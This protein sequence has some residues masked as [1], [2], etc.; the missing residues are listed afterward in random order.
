MP[1][2]CACTR[3]TSTRIACHSVKIIYLY[4]VLF[5]C[6]KMYVAVP[7]Q[8][9]TMRAIYF[10]ICIIIQI[11]AFLDISEM[12]QHYSITHYNTLHMNESWATVRKE[13]LLRVEFGAINHF[14]EEPK[15]S[16]AR[17]I[18]ARSNDRRGVCRVLISRVTS[19]QNERWDRA[20]MR[21]LRF[22]KPRRNARC[23]ITYHHHFA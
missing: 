19:K 22:H 6:Y 3:C 11:I 9:E 16:E 7:H 14:S 15:I 8:F 18:S 4:S 1:P 12:M 10:V 17:N 5:Q 23:S 13:K 20:R 2:V 21:I